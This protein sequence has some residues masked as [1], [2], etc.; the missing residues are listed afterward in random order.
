MMRIFR[1]DS[2]ICF[3]KYLEVK[4]L[5]FEFKKN[6]SQIMSIVALKE[7]QIYLN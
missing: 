1:I 3:I 5:A 7:T 2:V 6:I 4:Q